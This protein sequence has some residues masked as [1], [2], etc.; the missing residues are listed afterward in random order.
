M[1]M[2]QA[3]PLAGALLVLL[4]PT[5][6]WAGPVFSYA[7][8]QSSYSVKVG[9]TIDVKVFFQE[10]DSGPSGALPNGYLA[11]TGLFGVGVV[12]DYTSQPAQANGSAA[13]TPNAAFLIGPLSGSSATVTASQATLTENVGLGPFVLVPGLGPNYQIEVGVF[14]FKGLTPGTATITAGATGSNRVACM[15]CLL[16]CGA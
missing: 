7:F 8:D 3:L 5:Q 1:K 6:A 10:K 12:V 15:S 4:S 14:Q 9:S 16:G 13:V 2:S 11:N